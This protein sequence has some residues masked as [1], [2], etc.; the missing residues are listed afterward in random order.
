MKQIKSFAQHYVDLLVKLGLMRFSMLLAVVL[1]TLAI[2]IQVSITL[3]LTG[4]VQQSDLI[5][6]IFFG[7][8]IS[9]SAVYFLSV[10][11]DEVEDSRQRLAKLVTKLEEMRGRDMQLNAKLTE[12]INQ[13]NLEIEERQRAE[14]AREEAMQDLENEVYHREKAQLELAEQT[15]LLRSFIDASPDLIYYRNVNGQFSGCN[16]AMEDLIGRREKALVGLTPWDVYSQD[17][18]AK[19]VE[20]DKQ[21]F[22]KSQSL[23]YEQWL[24]YGDGRKAYFEL[25]K[26]PFMLGMEDDLGS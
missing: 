25:R 10:V 1:V 19:V 4:T 5:R 7:L 20:T 15:A 12:N 9:P 24:E 3:V 22:E 16:R 23:T 11:V 26:V 18:A 2:I 21:V 13:L 14:E 17:I 8:L 6:S